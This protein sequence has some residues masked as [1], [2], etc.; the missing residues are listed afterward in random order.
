MAQVLGIDVGTRTLGLAISDEL[1]RVAMPLTTLRRRNIRG[2]LAALREIVEDRGVREA[3]VGLPPQLDGARGPMSE[4]ADRVA[5]RIEG[6]LGLLVHRWDERMSTVSAERV[7]LQ[8]DVSRRRRRQVIDKLAATIFLQAW[9][10]SRQ[11]GAP[12]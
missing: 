12:A 8:A 3:V 11:S 4:E 9:L 7:L 5:R 10:D 6:D 2:D 1:Q